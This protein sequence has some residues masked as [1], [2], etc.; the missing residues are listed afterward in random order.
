MKNLP[1]PCK[2]CTKRYVSCHASCCDYKEYKRLLDEDKR[3]ISENKKR[4]CIYDEY[5]SGRWK[6]KS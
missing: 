5:I 4:V 1:S 2:N 6:N 3:I